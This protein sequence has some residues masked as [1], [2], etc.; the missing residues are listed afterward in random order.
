MV[1]SLIVGNSWVLWF[2]EMPESVGDVSALMLRIRIMILT[3]KT[4]GGES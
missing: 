4:E 1:P 2:S 3:H